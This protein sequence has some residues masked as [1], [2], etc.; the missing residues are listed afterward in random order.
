MKRNLLF[1]FSLLFSPSLFA[2]GTI[3]NF[4]VVPSSPTTADYVKVITGLQF[5]SGGCIVF[6]QGHTTNGSSTNAFAQHC[7]GM[8]PYICNTTDTFNLGYL[9]AG[10]NL[11]RLSVFTGYFGPPCTINTVADDIDSVTFY[12][13]PTVGIDT[14][15]PVSDKVSIFPNPFSQSATIFISADMQCKNTQFKMMNVLGETVKTIENI[16]ANEL[17]LDRGNLSKG[18]YF[19]QLKDNGIVITTGKIIIE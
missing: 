16:S 13:S 9:P 14:P 5:N 7:M 2:Q 8:L 15:E 3:L 17:K 12:V 19:Y 18:I 11:F 4:T 6:N 10:N 1:A